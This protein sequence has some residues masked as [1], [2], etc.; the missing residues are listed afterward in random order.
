M[1]AIVFVMHCFRLGK[2]LQKKYFKFIFYYAKRLRTYFSPL[3]HQTAK[4]NKREARELL[5]ERKALKPISRSKIHAMWLLLF[6][7]VVM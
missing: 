7:N 2:T 6:R 3:Y 4:Q 1:K 5:Y